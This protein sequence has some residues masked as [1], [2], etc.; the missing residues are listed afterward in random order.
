MR[1]KALLIL[2]VAAL[3]VT[4]ILTFL[5]FSSSEE[6]KLVD[7]EIS[8]TPV[9]YSE[10]YTL[11]DGGTL[12]FVTIGSEDAPQW[13]SFG[14]TIYPSELSA[15]EWVRAQLDPQGLMT[16]EHLDTALGEGLV[17]KGVSEWGK[18]REGLTDFTTVLVIRNEES[19][20]VFDRPN[21][22][23]TT[24]EEILNFIKNARLP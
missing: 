15:E 18:T 14:V 23:E 13:E 2:G 4:A 11:E 24:L 21:G 7:L 1:R 17:I 22:I 19:I 9:S 6:V 3:V 5:R 10:H 8:N 16:L 12:Q 20:L